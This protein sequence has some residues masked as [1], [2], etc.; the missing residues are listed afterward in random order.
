MDN[1]VK[2]AKGKKNLIT[3]IDNVLVG[4]SEDELS[5]TGVTII[6]FKKPSVAGYHV[7]G[8]AP[9]TRETDLLD[10]DKMIQKIDCIVFSGGSVFGLEAASGVCNELRKEKRG[11]QVDEFNIPIV[12]SAIL[13]DLHNGGKKD[14]YKN[15]YYDLGIKA[16]K[17]ISTNFQLGNYGAG[18]GSLTENLKGGLGSASLNVNNFNIGA[19]C[20]VNSFG[21]VTIDNKKNFWASP[22]EI[23]NEFGNLGF[24]KKIIKNNFFF[25]K[26]NLFNKREATTLVVVATDAKLTKSEATRISVIA[27]DGISRSIFPSHTQFDGDIIFTVS[28]GK[29]EI[30][31]PNNDLMILG[32]AAAICISRSIARAVY[33]AKPEKNDKKKSWSEL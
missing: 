2:F 8:G 21:S 23:D 33:N 27:H 25:K 16:L 13:F 28:T 20:I 17:N 30:K 14:F 11:F 22:F 29:K 4:N 6:Y 32:N 3:D 19:L 9:G 1:I 7:M 5:K 15:F 31:D 10:S 18:K 12:P 26:K 24:P